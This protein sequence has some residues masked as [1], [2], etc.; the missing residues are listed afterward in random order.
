[1]VY[2]RWAVPTDGEHHFEISAED[3]C[4]SNNSLGGSSLAAF[5]K[6]ILEMIDDKVA[7]I[8]G[9]EDVLVCVYKYSVV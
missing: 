2:E 7:R 8:H 4:L 1:M 6:T 3:T 9:K 5:R